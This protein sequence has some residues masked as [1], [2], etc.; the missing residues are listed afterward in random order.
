MCDLRA[1]S[2]VLRD[3]RTHQ[4]RNAE[5]AGASAVLVVDN[6]AEIFIP[7]MSDDHNGTA[8]EIP[9]VMVHMVRTSVPL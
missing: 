7:Y 5:N 1:R 8:V 2:G 6:R 4:V 3:A 9:S